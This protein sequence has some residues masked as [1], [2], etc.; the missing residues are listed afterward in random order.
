MNK[1]G[2][3]IIELTIV[4]AILAV[5]F[6]MVTPYLKG[7]RDKADWDTL[8]EDMIYTHFG[9]CEILSGRTGGDGYVEDKSTGHKVYLI[10]YKREF[11]EVTMKKGEIVN[12]ES[13]FK[14]KDSLTL[15][16]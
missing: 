3:T 8:N 14:R 1:K 13:K 15:E 16:Y 6:T 5:L 2:F 4:V 9:S 10:K 11:I 7:Y 12:I